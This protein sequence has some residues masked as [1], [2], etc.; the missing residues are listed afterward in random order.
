MIGRWCLAN[1]L[2]PLIIKTGKDD[3]RDKLQPMKKFHAALFEAYSGVLDGPA[4]VLN[5]MK[6]LWHYF[7]LPITDCEKS[8]QKIKKRSGPTSTWIRLICFL[9]QTPG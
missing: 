4:H 1:P 9:R 8:M 2:L 6:G 5:K 3:I 7:A